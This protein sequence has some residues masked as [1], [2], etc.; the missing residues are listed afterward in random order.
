MLVELSRPLPALVYI[1]SLLKRP[2]KMLLELPGAI[3]FMTTLWKTQ[4]NLSKITD[5]QCNSIDLASN[6]MKEERRPDEEQKTTNAERRAK[7]EATRGA[8]T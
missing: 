6:A 5:L 8:W 1:K 4:Q 7:N 2:R 3:P